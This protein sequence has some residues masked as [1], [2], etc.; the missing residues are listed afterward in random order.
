MDPTACCNTCG[1]SVKDQ[2]SIQCNL[3]QTKVGLKSI[4]LNYV[5]SQNIKF[6]NKTWYCYNC[7][8]KVFHTPFFKSVELMLD[9]Y[10]ILLRLIFQYNQISGSNDI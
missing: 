1:K 7:S 2:N 9:S 5:N 8:K 10:T 6:S 3:C 4:Y